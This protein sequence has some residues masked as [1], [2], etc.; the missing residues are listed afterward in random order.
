MATKKRVTT[1][2]RDGSFESTTGA[3][4]STEARTTEKLTTFRAP[5]KPTPEPANA[6]AT[7]VPAENTT[8]PRGQI[9]EWMRK[10]K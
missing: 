9:P 4:E 1:H 10:K 8:T 2:K 6:V 5:E 7:P 3:D